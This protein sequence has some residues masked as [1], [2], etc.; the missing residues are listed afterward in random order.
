[1]ESYFVITLI[2][3][4]AAVSGDNCPYQYLTPT[5]FIKTV[6]PAAWASQN[7]DNLILA[8]SSNLGVAQVFKRSGDKWTSVKNHTFGNVIEVVTIGKKHYAVGFPTKDIAL[9]YNLEKTG[10]VVFSNDYL[11]DSALEFRH[12]G[13]ALSLQGDS[14]EPWLLIGAPR[15]RQKDGKKWKENIGA[16]AAYKATSKEWTFKSTILPQ[17]INVNGFFGSDVKIHDRFALIGSTGIG[18]ELY[19]LNST[20]HA[21][22]LSS[23]VN[24][25][26]V[27]PAFGAK[28]ALGM[29]TAVVGG[30]G[31]LGVFRNGGTGFVRQQVVDISL[32][33]EGSANCQLKIDVGNR[34]PIA[35]IVITPKEDA[36]FVGVPWATVGDGLSTGVV[37]GL[38]IAKLQI[39]TILTR[40]PQHLNN[41]FGT[42]LI[43]V[44]NILGAGSFNEMKFA[45][46]NI[47]EFDTCDP[48]CV[49]WNELGCVKCK[50][51]FFLDH[52]RG[53]VECGSV[54][55]RCVKCDGVRCLYCGPGRWFN[56][57]T[58][59]C[60]T[61]GTGSCLHCDGLNC[62]TCGEEYYF[63]PKT[64]ECKP[65]TVFGADCFTCDDTGCN[66]C[67]SGD[68]VQYQCCVALK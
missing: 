50:E 61:C 4:F 2:M 41:A 60:E 23:F 1:M 55:K 29:S 15:T 51:N 8:S 17:V 20:G 22:Y 18:A 56:P 32:L 65:C 42:S 6:E 14:D 43:A 3:Y 36:I 35:A 19:T 13:A 38:T 44:S 12:F 45:L 47:T 24:T 62:I 66:S 11:D 48:N 59:T 7:S 52:N 63:D 27:I 68:A 49:E 54:E 34:D 58:Q 33:N 64:N 21:K 16:V 28:V 25:N 37:F 67:R 26:P 46:Y 31:K 53:C 57:A 30:N 5:S 9:L 40:P 10:H 39:K